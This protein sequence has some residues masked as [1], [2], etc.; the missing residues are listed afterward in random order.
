VRVSCMG[1]DELEQKIT[2]G[3]K[4]FFAADDQAASG[5]IGNPE[6]SGGKALR[7]LR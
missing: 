5:A 6:E 3:T 4:R 2:K 7:V 1:K